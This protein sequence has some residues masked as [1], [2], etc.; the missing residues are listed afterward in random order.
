M[1]SF[2]PTICP[3]CN[4]PLTI[5]VG[6]KSETLKL[7]CNNKECSGTLLKRLQRG[8]IALEIR[9]LGPKI[10]ENLMNAGIESSIDL[11]DP[12][13]FNSIKLISSGY[14]RKGRALTKILKAV[15]DTKSLPIKN[16]ILS[17]Q[18]E[19]IGKTFSEKIGMKISGVFLKFQNYL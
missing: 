12:E 8:I 17:L 5:E 6:E 3:A 9:G 7:M 11:F 13:K 1:K 19:D 10:I 2:F 15:N 4:K 16:A 18:Y 14:F